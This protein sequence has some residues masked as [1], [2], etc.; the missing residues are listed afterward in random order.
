[1]LS[2]N[3]AVKGRKELSVSWRRMWDQEN[4]LLVF[5]FEDGRNNNMFEN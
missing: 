2:R 5:V 4:V 3:F 1:M